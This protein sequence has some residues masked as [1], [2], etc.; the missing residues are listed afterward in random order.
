MF[1]IGCCDTLY[2]SLYIIYL[3][4]EYLD[5]GLSI[6]ALYETVV[7]SIMLVTTIIAYFYT[8]KLDINP[9]KI[10]HL[11]D[12]LLFIAIPAFFG[13]TIFTLIPAV[14]GGSYLNI[15]A[16]LL[17]LCQVLIQ[18][19]W[20]IDGLRRCANSNINK[21]TKPG[22]SLVTFLIGANITIWVFYTFSVKNIPARDE[23]Y[24]FY[25]DVVWTILSHITQPLIMFYRFH[26]SVCLADIW[27][28]SY[29]PHTH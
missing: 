10:S 27:K 6:N 15:V 5:I 26:S 16:A 2:L 11:D 13:H 8:S 4:S 20:I 25:G 24:K 18:T 7:V 1:Y 29:E 3:F 21:R 9:H 28:N 19:P 12:V 22:R 23:R 17:Q 14:Y